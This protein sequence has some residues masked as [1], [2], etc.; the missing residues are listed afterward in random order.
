[1]LL[2]SK[3]HAHTAFLPESQAGKSSL[4]LLLLGS[5]SGKPGIEAVAAEPQEDGACC[6][7]P[8][9][10][11]GKFSHPSFQGNAVVKKALAKSS[12]LAFTSNLLVK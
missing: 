4:T 6:C 7:Y 11:G 10:Q 2:F 3:C 1:M 9:C 12:L 8:L 5:Q